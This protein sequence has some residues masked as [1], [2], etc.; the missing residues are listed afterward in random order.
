MTVGVQ[1]PESVV[2]F[3]QLYADVMVVVVIPPFA[4]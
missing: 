4:S 2:S 1:V 3:A